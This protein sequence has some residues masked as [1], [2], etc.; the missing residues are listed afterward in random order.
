MGE[1]SNHLSED[2]KFKF[3]EVEW[4]QVIG[5][6]NLLVHEY[7][8]IDSK[9]VWEVI[10]NDIPTLKTTLLIIYTFLNEKYY[11]N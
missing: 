9:I 6:W 5:M 10:K 3:S 2:I 11:Q 7:F 8:G 1:A 4:V